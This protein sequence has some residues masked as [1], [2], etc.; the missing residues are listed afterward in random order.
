ML[1]NTGALSIPEV[2]RRM[3]VIGAGIIGLEMGSVWRRLGAQVTILEALPAF[4]GVADEAIAKEA[5][6]VFARQ[7]LKIETGVKIT[8]IEKKKPFQSQ[9]TASDSSSKTFE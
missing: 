1:S 7:G 5:A 6:K 3:G 4:L 8:K 9:Y 2:P